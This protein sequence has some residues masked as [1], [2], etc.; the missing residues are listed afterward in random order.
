MITVSSAV[1]QFGLNGLLDATKG[2]N[3]LLPLYANTYGV[4]PFT[5]SKDSKPPNLFT[6]RFDYA[7]LIRAYGPDLFPCAVISIFGD[8]ALGRR[9]MRVTPSEFSGAVW[10]SVDFWIQYQTADFVDGEAM[11]FA[12]ECAMIDTFNNQNNYSYVPEG[13][14]YNNEIK[15]DQGRMMFEEGRFTQLIA[16]SLACNRVT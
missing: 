16:C 2:F 5:L 6:G 12:I 11:F 15:I 10:L 14:S 7:T 1:R 13:V 9:Q 4:K 3:Y 8:D